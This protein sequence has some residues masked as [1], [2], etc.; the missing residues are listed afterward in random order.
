MGGQGVLARGLAVLTLGAALVLAQRPVGEDNPVKFGP[1]PT[2]PP[3]GEQYEPRGVLRSVEKPH[4]LLG[5][6]LAALVVLI[7]SGAKIGGGAVLDAVY[8]LVLKLG[9]DEAIPLASITVFGGAVCDFF[10]N[11]WKKPINSN[12]R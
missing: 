7:S 8:I 4:Q 6:L 3:Q 2:F 12:S 1:V 11:L 9:P 10:L 5:I